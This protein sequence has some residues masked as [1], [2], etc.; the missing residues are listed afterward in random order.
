MPLEAY[1]RVAAEF[2]P[3]DRRR[4]VE[5]VASAREVVLVCGKNFKLGVPDHEFHSGV[6]L[7]DLGS[8]FDRHAQ[9]R[10]V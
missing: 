6:K 9:G 5:V 8:P 4:L 10:E 1:H 3:R 7:D 2:H